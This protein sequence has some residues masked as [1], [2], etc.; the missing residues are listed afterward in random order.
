[1]MKS[2]SKESLIGVFGML[3]NFVLLLDDQKKIDMLFRGQIDKKSVKLHISELDKAICEHK[4]QFSL[5]LVELLSSIPDITFES[6]FQE[7]KIMKLYNDSLNNLKPY[8]STSGYID[9][10]ID[11]QQ[12]L[13]DCQFFAKYLKMNNKKLNKLDKEIK[14]L[15]HTICDFCT[16]YKLVAFNRCVFVYL[17][18]YFKTVNYVQYIYDTLLSYSDYYEKMDII[19]T[20]ISRVFAVKEKYNEMIKHFKY[21]VFHFRKITLNTQ[22]EAIKSLFSSAYNNTYSIYITLVR[23]KNKLLKFNEI[24]SFLEKTLKLSVSEIQYDSSICPVDYPKL[25]IFVD[26]VLFDWFCDNVTIGDSSIIFIMVFSCRRTKYLIFS[27][28]L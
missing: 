6:D 20:N 2:D 3:F 13:A 24:K 19:I 26:S 17:L 1:M 7:E 27:S 28:R 11:L 4:K 8:F 22:D 12:E 15:E 10:L 23:T 21:N 9:L 25:P 14:E 18:F 5:N 16:I